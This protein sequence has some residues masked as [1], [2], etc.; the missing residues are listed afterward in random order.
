MFQIRPVRTPHDYPRM[1]ELF[2]FDQPE[3]VTVAHLAEADSRIPEPPAQPRYDEQGRLI[4]H[5][6]HRLLITDE[7]DYAMGY[8]QIWRAPWSPPGWMFGYVL[9]D[10]PFR[11]RG[12]GQRLLDAIEGIAR[13]KKAEWIYSEVRDHDTESIAWLQRRGYEIERHSFESVLDLST[14]A[15]TPFSNAVE[16]VAASGLRFSSLADLPGE[17]TERKLHDL[18]VAT[19]RDIPG[20]PGDHMPFTEWRKW[21]IEGER[22]PH[23]GV[24]LALDGDRVVGTSI[25]R[26]EETGAFYTTYTGVHR[27]YRGR[28]LALAL[29][30]LSVRVAKRYGA[31]YM[32]TNND[33]T[34]EPMLAVNRKLGYRPEPGLYRVRK[35]LV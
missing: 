30:L 3:P 16:K 28:G 15:E 24:I 19:E 5:C 33:S 9:T 31:P 1:A 22:V 12:L 6:R 7:K 13:E 29:K 4:S 2:T 18:C 34:N 11:R 17:A 26:R 23:D 10:G 27:E 32:R 21:H 14:F 8:G 35:R 20:F 25:L